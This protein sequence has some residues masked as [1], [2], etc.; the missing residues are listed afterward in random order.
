MIY[1][2]VNVLPVI[3]YLNSNLAIEQVAVARD[4]GA[5]GVFLISHQ[6]D[7]EDLVAVA[8]RA[9][10]MHPGLKIGINLL[11]QD[12]VRA[13]EWAEGLELD[14]VWADDMGV[15][16]KG[17]NTMAVELSAFAK[18]NPHIHLFASVAFKY[19]PPEPNPALAA[20]HAL[21]LGFIPTTSGG[22][23]GFA[24][25]V[26]KISN[27]SAA[28]GGCLAVASG[29]TPENVSNYVP[30]LSHILVSTGIGL[31]E[32]R[33]DPQKLKALIESCKKNETKT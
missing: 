21:N 1:T 8:A 27:M 16:S 19:R 3:H 22:A 32:Y 31:D 33:I 9:K 28:T 29:M 10:Q 14:M 2:Q 17:G 23:T 30:F 15:D 11:S 20:I 6:G 12:A 24:P 18:E 13:C 7:D 26:R 25:D 5:D 4:C